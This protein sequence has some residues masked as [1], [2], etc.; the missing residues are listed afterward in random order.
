M[1]L[2]K[3]DIVRW[4]YS[5]GAKE[6]GKLTPYHCKCCRAIFNGEVL[7]D[8]Y[9]VHSHQM[10]DPNPYRKVTFRPE[11]VG[12]RIT[13]TEKL[14]NFYNYEQCSPFT[15]HNWY[16]EE[17]ILD[18]RHPNNSSDDNVY[19]RKDA[20]KKRDVRIQKLQE[21][22]GDWRKEIQSLVRR[23]NLNRDNVKRLKAEMEEEREQSER[24]E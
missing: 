12:E 10:P 6:L 23:I 8:L 11:D 3:G 9:W 13:I 5:E 20:E 1:N 16:A 15:A 18:L 2:K 19:V 14:G 21:Q 7:I 24:R 4:R 17:D 22:I